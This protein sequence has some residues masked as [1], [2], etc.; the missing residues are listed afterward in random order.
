MKL[1]AFLLCALA[2]TA[3]AAQTNPDTPTFNVG[4]TIFA[5]YTH[6]DAPDAFNVSRAYINITGTLNHRISFRVTPDVARESGSGSSLTGSQTF[7]LKYAFAQFA[8]DDWTTHGSW[9]RAGV[10]QT[11]L[12]DYQESIYRYRFQ[13]QT[14]VEREGYLTSS[15]AGLSARYVLP[16]DLGDIQAGYYNGEGYSHT[17]TNDEKAFQIR[18]TLRPAKGIRTTLFVDED[19]YAAAAKRQR[20]VGEVTFESAHLNA[21]A[22]VLH[23][24]DRDVTG[25]GWSVWLTPRLGNGWE[26]LLRHDDNQPDNHVADQKHK[27]DIAGIAYW[28]LEKGKLQSAVMIDYDRFRQPGFGKP[29][30]TRYGLKL[31]IAY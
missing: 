27:R 28:M 2:A 3:A 22:D 20:V 5:D 19:H 12:I 31:L 30:D 16:H 11:P 8:L 1:I 6:S 15:D 18:G 10:Q 24:N 7:R 26:L 25:K 21:G 29:D 14:F 23:A 13:G 17:E 4:T 9:I